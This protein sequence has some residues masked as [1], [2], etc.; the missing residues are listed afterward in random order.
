LDNFKQDIEKLLA[1]NSGQLVHFTEPQKRDLS[2]PINKQNQG[3]YVISHI[4]LEPQNVINFLKE[5]KA[6]K[7]ILRHLINVLEIPEPEKPRMPRKPKTN[8]EIKEVV[9]KPAFVKTTAGKDGKMKLEEI[10][11]KLDELVG[12]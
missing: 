9:S 8:K 4:S 10:D 3:I 11:K 12:I 5:L 6:N 1:N 7:Q 2:Y